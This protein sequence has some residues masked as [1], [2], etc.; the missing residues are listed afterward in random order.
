MHLLHASGWSVK[1]ESLRSDGDLVNNLQL[2][3]WM[4][5]YD[6]WV[7]PKT[8]NQANRSGQICRGRLGL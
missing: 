4:K 1:H 7:N 2:S 3:R 5:R 8:S 6:V